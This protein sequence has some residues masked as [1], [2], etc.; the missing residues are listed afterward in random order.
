MDIRKYIITTGGKPPVKGGGRTVYGNSEPEGKTVFLGGNEV[1]VGGW[2]AHEVVRRRARWES[3][4]RDPKMEP[5]S[6]YS[7]RYTISGQDAVESLVV[8]RCAKFGGK[9]TT[10]PLEKS[11][12]RLSKALAAFNQKMSKSHVS[13][14]TRFGVPSESYLTVSTI[15]P[16]DIKHAVPETD[17]DA[18]YQIAESVGALASGYAREEELESL[19]PPLPPEVLP[20]LP[21]REVSLKGRKASEVNKSIVALELASIPRASAIE[22]YR[23][24]IAEVFDTAAFVLERSAASGRTEKG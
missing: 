24:D 18:L 8:A 2:V 4:P 7:S 13:M 6:R 15:T 22:E 16:K 9:I 3:A 14:W 12:E 19:K 21:R 10:D 23:G 5:R 17:P 11:A 1:V 20:P